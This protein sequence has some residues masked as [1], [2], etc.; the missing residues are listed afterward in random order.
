MR[1]RHSFCVSFGSAVV[2]KSN[3]HG[4]EHPE[5]VRHYFLKREFSEGCQSVMHFKFPL[6]A[7]LLDQASD[8]KV[9]SFRYAPIVLLAASTI[10][11]TF[12]L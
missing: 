4:G 5:E 12:V 3:V 8:I 1:W 11:S 7:L 9:P 6:A 10:T 2:T